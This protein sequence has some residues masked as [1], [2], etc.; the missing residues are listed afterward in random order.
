MPVFLEVNL[1]HNY[2]HFEWI[3]IFMQKHHL[4]YN[5]T[6]KRRI[7]PNIPE[8]YTLPQKLEG[9]KSQTCSKVN[10]KRVSIK[11]WLLLQTLS[12]V[13]CHRGFLYPSLLVLVR[14]FTYVT[15]WGSWATWPV[16]V[17]LLLTFMCTWLQLFKVFVYK[18]I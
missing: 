13:H 18:N 5:I 10:Q 11:Q 2:M 12:L 17:R 6:T 8:V 15:D 7:R 16:V 3:L 1:L 14:T 9:V 4:W